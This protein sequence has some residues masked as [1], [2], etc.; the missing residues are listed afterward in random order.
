MGEKHCYTYILRGK[1]SKLV[2]MKPN[3]HSEKFI[4]YTNV[5]DIPKIRK[6]GNHV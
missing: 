5:L 6:T 1:L 4:F 2:Y 3:I